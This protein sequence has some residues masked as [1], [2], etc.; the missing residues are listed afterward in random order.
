MTMLMWFSKLQLKVEGERL[1]KLS[2]TTQ[3][4]CVCLIFYTAVRNEKQTRLLVYQGKA[5]ISPMSLNSYRIVFGKRKNWK[6]IQFGQ[7]RSVKF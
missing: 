4:K 1:V 3:K 6:S 2:Q 5:L 7:Y